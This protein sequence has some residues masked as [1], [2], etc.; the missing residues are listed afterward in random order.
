MTDLQFGAL[1]RAIRIR[2]RWRQSDLAERAGVSQTI[3]SRIER[4]DLGTV[5]LATVRR[6]AVAL[7]IQVDLVGRW[8]GADAHRLLSARHSALGESVIRGLTRP[9]WIFAPEVSFSIFGDRGV[10]DI[11][12]WHRDAGILLVI[13]LKTQIVDINELVGTFDR[14]VR[15]AAQ[16]ARDHGWA[17]DERTMVSAWVIVADSRTNRR[18]VHDHAAMLRAAYPLDGRHVRTWLK[19]P[20]GSI[21]CLSFWAPP[22]RA[23]GAAVKRVRVRQ[24]VR[25]G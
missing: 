19:K 21:R 1:V 24:A 20:R 3:V 10:V 15:N 17:V 12:A 22:Q 25:A 9:G 11:L 5:P 2:L 18:R 14:K 8:R 4:G 6:V 13:E 16:I 7:E 23:G